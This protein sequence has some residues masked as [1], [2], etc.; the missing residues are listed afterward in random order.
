MDRLPE[1]ELTV[2]TQNAVP[3]T[4][5]VEPIRIC[6]APSQG[7]GPEESRVVTDT[8]AQGTTSTSSTATAKVPFKEQVIAYA[9]VCV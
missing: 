1:L 3:F 4:S 5:A 8:S 6:T 9:K 2:H 7:V